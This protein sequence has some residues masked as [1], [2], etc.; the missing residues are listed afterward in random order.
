[1]FAAGGYPGSAYASHGIHLYE[2]ILS[3]EPD[4]TVREA[5]MGQNL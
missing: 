5:I 3:W 4:W 1:M 2:R